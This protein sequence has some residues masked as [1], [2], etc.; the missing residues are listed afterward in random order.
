MHMADAHVSLANVVRTQLMNIF[1]AVRIGADIL[2]GE[3]AHLNPFFTH[4]GLLKTPSAA[5]QIF[6]NSL[7]IPISV[8]DT[9]DEGGA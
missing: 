8:G 3:G 7:N 1:A 6:T 4:G 2:R 9:A 5:Q